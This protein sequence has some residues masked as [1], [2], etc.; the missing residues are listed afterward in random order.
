MAQI[1]A[2]DSAPLSYLWVPTRQVDNS[3]LIYNVAN[4]DKVL[5]FAFGFNANVKLS[6]EVKSSTVGARRQRWT[7][8]R[9][10]K[11]KLY[12]S[13]WRA[14][15]KISLTTIR[16]LSPEQEIRSHASY[17]K[18]RERALYHSAIALCAL[19][20]GILERFAACQRSACEA[21]RLV[22]FSPR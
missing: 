5:S 19:L 15:T 14:L 20:S 18:S 3:W 9:V 11:S 12:F 22:Y 8:R 7:L 16:L 6:N 2:P 21:G 17:F 4:P 13:L 10:G 1:H